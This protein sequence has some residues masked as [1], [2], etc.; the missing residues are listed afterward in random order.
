MHTTA[1]TMSFSNWSEFEFVFTQ[2]YLTAV[3]VN[4]CLYAEVN[5]LRL[6]VLKG[7]DD[8]AEI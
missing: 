4:N 1:L 3:L 7:V 6:C 5:S 2:S 8:A